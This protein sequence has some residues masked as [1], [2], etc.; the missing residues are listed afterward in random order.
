[1]AETLDNQMVKIIRD[2]RG[3]ISQALSMMQQLN[4]RDLANGVTL[5]TS[6][7]D[8]IYEIDSE[9]DFVDPY[10]DAAYGLAEAEAEA[11]QA[12]TF[13]ILQTPR[14]IGRLQR[15]RDLKVT[16][17]GGNVRV[18]SDEGVVSTD[19]IGGLLDQLKNVPVDVP[20]GS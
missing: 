1:M 20:E 18:V 13:G 9:P 14:R 8:A 7:E 4:A 10:L 19:S 15:V 2:A 11:G 17:F 12:L 6:I 16:L 5:E 3:S